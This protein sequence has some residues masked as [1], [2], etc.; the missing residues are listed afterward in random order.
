[1][2]DCVFD[3]GSADG[4]VYGDHLEPGSTAV[5]QSALALI[6]LAGTAMLGCGVDSPARPGTP[7]P[8]T[9]TGP[10]ESI[11]PSEWTNNPRLPRVTVSW[12][13][14]SIWMA[15]VQP[16]ID[17]TTL[18]LV[19]C[20]DTVL[21]LHPRME[22]QG[23]AVKDSN[24]V[25]RDTWEAADGPIVQ[26]GFLELWPQP[27]WWVSECCD[28]LGNRFPSY[29]VGPLLRGRIVFS[30]GAPCWASRTFP[31]TVWPDSIPAP[32]WLL[33]SGM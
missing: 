9:A 28:S 8:S 2:G 13:A 14:D 23:F 30:A 19:V 5:M 12:Q 15:V 27:Q 31:V 4:F 10:A 3:L 6:L 32:P 24:S 11:W 7:H 26:W 29:N 17:G 25:L 1:M 22:F 20:S 16:V 18:A 33:K 21:A